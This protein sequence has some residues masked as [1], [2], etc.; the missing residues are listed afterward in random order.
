VR[1]IDR[2]ENPSRFFEED[3]VRDGQRHTSSGSIQ[4]SGADLRL[5]LRNLM[6]N[7]G[8][9][10]VAQAGGPSE[11]PQFGDGDKGAQLAQLHSR[12]LSDE[13]NH[14]IG[15]IGWRRLES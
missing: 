13:F 5:E 4:Q 1:A 11:M 2:A 12:S 10:E 14:F 7:R 3:L 8:L 15:R 9:R 6:G